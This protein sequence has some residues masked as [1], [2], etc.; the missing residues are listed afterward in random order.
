M[1]EWR[2]LG[3]VVDIGE[4]DS[5]YTNYSLNIPVTIY[6]GYTPIAVIIYGFYADTGIRI[7]TVSY[8]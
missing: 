4:I 3:Y 1:D 5:D 8:M 7:V 6:N 2:D